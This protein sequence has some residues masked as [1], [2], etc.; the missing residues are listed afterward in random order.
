MKKR[1]F[2]SVALACLMAS[3]TGTPQSADDELCFIDVAGAMENPVELKLSELGGDVRYVALET[4]DSCLIGANPVIQLL[5]KQIAVIQ[6]GN[7]FLFDKESGKFLTKVGHAGE[8]PEAFSTP[9]PTYNDVDGLLYFMRQPATLQKYDVQGQYRGKLTMATPPAA[10]ADFC[11][12]DSLVIG[13]YNNWALSYNASSLAYYNEAGERVDTIPNM[14]PVSEV[15]MQDIASISVLKQGI[16]GIVMSKF[17]NGES[18]IN[19]L[20]IPFLWKSDGQVRYKEVFNDTIY[21]V[22]R[23]GLVPY[24]AFATGKWHLPAE[25]QL[26]FIDSKSWLLPSCVFETKDNVFFQCMQGHPQTYNG[27]YDR[28]AKTTHMCDEAK[29]ITDDLG[30]FMPFRP[31]TCSLQGEY[32]MIVGSDKGMDWLEENPEAAQ[33]GKLA[34]LK[35]LT[36]D[37]NPVVVITVPK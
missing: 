19:I 14:Y 16:L 8:D 35:D 33:S 31:Q 27:I 32:G 28:Q 30:G 5:D 22:E 10:P 21:T 37:S 3:C 20:G 24:M 17:N 13:H 12:T 29:G 34:L 6:G 7:C 4:T 11:F 23:N 25:E 36:E 9:T 15:K 26:K 2:Y 1:W 18:A